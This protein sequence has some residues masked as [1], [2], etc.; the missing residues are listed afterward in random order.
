MNMFFNE[1]EIKKILSD[2]KVNNYNKDKLDIRTLDIFKYLLRK[3]FKK[4]EIKNMILEYPRLLTN[5]VENISSNYENLEK[6]FNK[7]TNKLILEC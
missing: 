6:L 4:L 1:E 3:K 5:S 7:S 2:E